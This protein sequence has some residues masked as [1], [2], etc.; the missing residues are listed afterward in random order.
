MN[1]TIEAILSQDSAQARVLQLISTRNGQLT[2]EETERYRWIRDNY[3]AYYSIL[4]KTQPER[5]VLPYLQSMMAVL[6]F[7]SE[8]RTTLLLGAGGGAL[9][10]YLNKYFPNSVNVAID[11]DHQ[12]IE[13]T[14]K[15]F[16]NEP[17]DTQLIKNTDAMNFISQSS[18]QHFD[19]IFVDLFSHGA[20]PNFF[21][22]VEFY[23]QCKRSLA[24]GVIAFNLILDTQADF[25]LIMNHL[26]FVFNKRCLCLT[27]PDYK[28]IIVLAFDDSVELEKDVS[29]L[30]E[31][32][33]SLNNIYD[34]EFDGLLDE[35]IAT[36]VCVNNVLQF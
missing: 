34:V 13:V 9:L 14:N 2:I 30:R 3:S 5:L 6:L 11:N 19:L 17:Q 24:T 35:I 32:C 25:K 22:Y 21:K 16:L 26:L 29:V 36:N 28:N 1:N 23:Q 12:M 8:L 15:Y 20:I 4:D 27:V 33:K 18:K 7:I 10:R 31:N